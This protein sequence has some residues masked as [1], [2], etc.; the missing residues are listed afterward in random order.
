MIELLLESAMNL[1]RP[2]VRVQISWAC[3]APPAPCLPDAHRFVRQL[4]T[5][6]SKI[7]FICAELTRRIRPPQAMRTVAVV[8]QFAKSPKRPGK[9]GEIAPA[10]RGSTQEAALHLSTR[11]TFRRAH[12]VLLQLTTIRAEATFT[13]R[14]C[15]ALTSP[16]T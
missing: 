14:R 1:V 6:P 11:A 15:C 10:R 13:S 9:A 8:Q 4:C 3:I 5:C 16:A 12:H 7:H 2:N